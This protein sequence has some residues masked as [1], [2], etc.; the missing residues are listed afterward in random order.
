[1]EESKIASKA[2][3]WTKTYDKSRL[4]ETI[5]VHTNRDTT[6]KEGFRQIKRAFTVIEECLEHI[7]R[8]FETRCKTNKTLSAFLL[9]N[10]NEE[11]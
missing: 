3:D 5:V 10:I 4:R 8:Y 1:M 6:I 2:T 11:L 9:Q 7:K